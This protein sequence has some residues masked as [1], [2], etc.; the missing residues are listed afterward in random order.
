MMGKLGFI[1]EATTGND[2]QIVRRKKLRGK[3]N[4]VS[5]NVVY[6]HTSYTDGSV[7]SCFPPFF[8]VPIT[9]NRQNSKMV[10]Q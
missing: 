8:N 10:T 3:K 5:I 4:G 6:N 1:M 7:C 9:S 2:T